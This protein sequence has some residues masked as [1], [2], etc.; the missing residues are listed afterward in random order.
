MLTSVLSST[1][2]CPIGTLYDNKS[3]KC[4]LCAKGSYQ[5]KEGQTNCKKCEKGKSTNRSGAVSNNDCATGEFLLY[6]ATK[7]FIRAKPL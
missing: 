4:E 6:T 7:I 3:F 1:V 2:A 5:D